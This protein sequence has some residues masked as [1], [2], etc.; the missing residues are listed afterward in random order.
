MAARNDARLRREQQRVWKQI[1]AEN[2]RS[3]RVRP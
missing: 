2:R 1:S 3:G